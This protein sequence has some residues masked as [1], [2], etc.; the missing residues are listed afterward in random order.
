MITN[1]Y[2][3]K[4]QLPNKIFRIYYRNKYDIQFY[5]IYYKFFYKF[6]IYVIIF[7]GYL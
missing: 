2:F 3:D 6:S 4:K 7:L 5:H 1:K